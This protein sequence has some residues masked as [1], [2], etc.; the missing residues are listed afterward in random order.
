MLTGAGVGNIIPDPVNVLEVGEGN[1]ALLVKMWVVK[2]ISVGI[3]NM[4]LTIRMHTLDA[5]F[6][7]G[8]T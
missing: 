7:G 2:N 8:I 5:F 4:L 3:V 6:D 1:D